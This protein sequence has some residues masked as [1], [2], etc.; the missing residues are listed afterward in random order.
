MS[1]YFFSHETQDSPVHIPS[2]QGEE[3]KIQ[4]KK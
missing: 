3:T 1:Q 4:N 2:A